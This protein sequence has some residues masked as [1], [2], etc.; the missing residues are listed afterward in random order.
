MA[1]LPKIVYNFNENSATT[2]RDYSENGNDGTGTN[3]TIAAS[4]RVG[5]DA[6]FNSTTDKITVTDN[7]ILNGSSDCS[8]HLGIQMSAGTGTKK[9]LYKASQIDLEYNY[10]T[11]IMT[12][13]LEVEGLTAT[14]S[15]GALSVGTFYD[16]DFVWGSS[17]ITL[18]QDNVSVDTNSYDTV[19]IDSS[20]SAMTI[21]GSSS[22][23]ANFLLNEFKL[24][25]ES[26]TS[27]IRGALIDGQNGILS[28]DTVNDI[29]NVGDVIYTNFNTNPMFAVVSWVGTSTDFRFLPLT[30]GIANGMQFKRGAHLWDTTRQWGLKIDDTPQVSFFDG[31]SK[32]SEI[33]AASKKTISVTK[34]GIVENS[35]TKTS[36][37][38]LTDTDS[39]IYASG[40]TTITF[41]STPIDNKRYEVVNVGTGVITLDGNGKNINGSSTQP[42]NSKYDAAKTIYTGTE[43]IFD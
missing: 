10:T 39:I 15:T 31:Q 14:V 42:L 11:N 33:F 40:N 23:S 8:I 30:E 17:T 36:N 9:I 32:S 2:I 26:I 22:D 7:S 41:P 29:Y 43:H 38:T 20:S 4:T 12:L 1:V 27:A 24:Y 28:D 19:N 5:N 6:V 37:Y 25:D 3:V 34:N 18:Y 16:F 13:S 35:K 21:G